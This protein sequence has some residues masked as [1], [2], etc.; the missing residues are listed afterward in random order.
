MFDSSTKNRLIFYNIIYEIFNEIT[1]R[2]ITKIF[3]NQD[4]FF[5]CPIYNFLELS[6]IKAYSDSL[7]YNYSLHRKKYLSN[8]CSL[9]NNI[10]KNKEGKLINELNDIINVPHAFNSIYNFG[11]YEDFCSTLCNWPGEGIKYETIDIMFFPFHRWGQRIKNDSILNFTQISIILGELPFPFETLL[12]LNIE[13][14]KKLMNLIFDIIENLFND[15]FYLYIKF[16][17]K[18]IIDNMKNINF[19]ESHGKREVERI[20]MN[21]ILFSLLINKYFGLKYNEF[22]SSSYKI[23]FEELFKLINFDIKEFVNKNSPFPYKIVLNILSIYGKNITKLLKIIWI[24]KLYP[25]VFYSLKKSNIIFNFESLDIFGINEETI[26]FRYFNY[27]N[28]KLTEKEILLFF[29]ILDN[30]I[31][32]ELFITKSESLFNK[33]LLQN[34]STNYPRRIDYKKYYHRG[35]LLNYIELQLYLIILSL[36][37]IQK[38]GN[39]QN[40]FSNKIDSII[41]DYYLKSFYGKKIIHEIDQSELESKYMF[42]SF[43]EKNNLVENHI[44]ITNLSIREINVTSKYEPKSITFKEVMNKNFLNRRYLFINNHKEKEIEETDIK[45]RNELINFLFIPLHKETLPQYLSTAQ[46]IYNDFWS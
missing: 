4:P 24:K 29:E 28:I 25:F 35:Y 40:D 2:A 22:Y 46:K 1:H 3:Y 21:Y 8:I 41:K 7:L 38:L 32:D 5:N 14:Y 27:F 26:D 31:N 15:I 34:T 43:N 12:S 39:A 23:Y 42:Y 33:I 30:F 10:N 11:L 19:K 36:E 9:N 20:F 44:K 17:D 16:G 37:K 45:Y 18:K 13:E 6:N